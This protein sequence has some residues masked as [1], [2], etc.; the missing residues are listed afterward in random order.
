MDIAKNIRQKNIF[1][2][3]EFDK[4]GGTRTCM[5][6]LLNFFRDK[7][8][9]VHMFSAHTT[10]RSLL[11]YLTQDNCHI[12]LHTFAKRPWW[13]YR[14]GFSQIWEFLQILPF[15]LKYRPVLCLAS[16]GTPTQWLSPSL[17]F[18]PFVYILHS[19]VAPLGQSARLIYSLLLYFTR[20]HT[21]LVTVSEYSARLLEKNWHQK[22]HTLYNATRYPW[23][24][25]ILSSSKTNPTTIITVGHVINYKNPFVW[26][27]VAKEVLRENEEVS[28][29]WYGDGPLLKKM[30]ELTK[31]IPQIRLPGTTQNPADAYT[32]GSIYFHPSLLESHGIAVIEAM[33]FGLPCVTADCGGLIE[34][35]IHNKTGFIYSPHDITG[36][37]SG[38]K[39]LL[40]EPA[41]ALAMGIA[42]QER[43]RRMFMPAQWEETLSAIIDSTEQKYDNANKKF[44]SE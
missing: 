18:V 16:I 33:S 31:N 44:S 37:A 20:Q 2:I 23:A 34:S 14:A 27:D 25:R 7:P 10:A 6:Q 1:L 41:S 13:A 42:G 8:F 15:F 40:N 4:S 43:V 30:R 26:L 19:C 9:T 38:I 3:A 11:Q 39:F 12:Q 28:F 21:T 36:F 35:V 5:E 24:T 29:V 32:R 17:F 22:A